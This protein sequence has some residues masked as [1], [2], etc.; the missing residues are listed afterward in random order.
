[1]NAFPLRAKVCGYT[2]ARLLHVFEVR[3]GV[4]ASLADQD[5]MACKG[6]VSCI[7]CY[8]LTVVPCDIV[9]LDGRCCTMRLALCSDVFNHGEQKEKRWS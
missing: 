3:G 2:A 1:M 9:V 6:I 8:E 7:K 5:G 4:E